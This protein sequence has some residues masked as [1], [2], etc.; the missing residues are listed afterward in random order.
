MLGS[1]KW[2]EN[3]GRHSENP[4]S[5][6]NNKQ[7]DESSSRQ[8]DFFLVLIAKEQITQTK[9]VIAKINLFST[10]NFV[11]TRSQWKV[12]Q[13]KEKTVSTTT[14]LNVSEDDNSDEHI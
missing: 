13:N 2:I 4:R 14:Q 8:G 5:F 3:L 1:S 6:Y 11:K 10:A 12:L 9:I 7:K